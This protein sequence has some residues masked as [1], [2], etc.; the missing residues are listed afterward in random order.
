M[1]LNKWYTVEDENHTYGYTVFCPLVHTPGNRF[2]GICFI[3]NDQG[4]PVFLLY[5]IISIDFITLGEEYDID[6][7]MVVKYLFD[8]DIEYKFI[9]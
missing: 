6:T 1:E 2:E 3:N 8:L 7:R 9:G 5:G 4:I